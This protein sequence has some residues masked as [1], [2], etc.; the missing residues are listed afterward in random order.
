MI[1]NKKEFK[2]FRDKES[3]AD[4]IGWSDVHFS[5]IL[6]LKQC[7]FNGDYGEF[8]AGVNFFDSTLEYFKDETYDKEM[9]MAEI[10]RERMGPLKSGT[11]VW[12]YDQQFRILCRLLGRANQ[13]ELALTEGIDKSMVIQEIAYR[14]NKGQGQNVFVTGKPGSGKS[15][16]CGSIALEVTKLTGGLA[17]A[18]RHVVYTPLEFSKMYNDV[19][20]TPE[21]SA[22][23]FDEAG[24]T[25]GSR[26]ALTKANKIFAKLCQIIRHRKLLVIFNAPDMSFMDSQARKMLHWWF[27]TQKLDTKNRYCKMK[28]SVVEVNQMTG[29]LMFPYPRFEPKDVIT[30]LWVKEPPQAWTTIYEERTKDYKDNMAVR[31][32]AELADLDETN[33]DRQYI[34]Y[35]DLR[36]DGKK[37]KEI[38]EIMDL[39]QYG[40]TKFERRYKRIG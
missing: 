39:N 3:D 9:D 35:R 32:E 10:Q 12:F 37:Q 31:A 20:E 34:Q 11:D 13:G 22:L 14:L 17:S 33:R 18:E 27:E 6:S 2:S 5:T 7:R 26:D 21:G 4:K 38:K 16:S 29:T 19:K 15:W 25:F 28:P 8:K 30:Q 23:I 1:G 40:A 36:N 24:V